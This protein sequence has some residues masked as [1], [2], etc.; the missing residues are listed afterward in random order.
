METPTST[1]RKKTQSLRESIFS[2]FTNR[3]RRNIP[4][5]QHN[6]DSLLSWVKEYISG[7]FS[8]G[9]VYPFDL[10]KKSLLLCELPSEKPTCYC[11]LWTWRVGN[12]TYGLL[13]G[14]SHPLCNSGSI[15]P[16][17]EGNERIQCGLWPMSCLPHP[18]WKLLSISFAGDAIWR[19]WGNVTPLSNAAPPRDIFSV[20]D[21]V[22]TIEMSCQ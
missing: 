8:Y 22:Q 2:T 14:K 4:F 1:P 18:F 5:S 7:H 13:G 3:D 12:S 11:N 6:N 9:S 10:K 16:K 17:L 20:E 21:V 19:R 15:S